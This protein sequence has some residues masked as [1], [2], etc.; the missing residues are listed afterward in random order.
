MTTI[1]TRRRVWSISNGVRFNQ[2][3]NHFRKQVS[4]S[5]SE[6]QY[7]KPASVCTSNPQNSAT[8]LETCPMDLENPF[9][10]LPPQYLIRP[11]LLAFPGLPKDA[12]LVFNLHHPK[13]GLPHL[14]GMMTSCLC[15]LVLLTL[16]KYSRAWLEHEP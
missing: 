10:Q 9:T 7:L 3:Y 16:N 5:S 2:V 13:G 15:D 14:M 6:H 12:P 4:L 1:I 8:M 11:P